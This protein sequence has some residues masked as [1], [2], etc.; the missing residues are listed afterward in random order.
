MNMNIFYKRSILLFVLLI[1]FSVFSQEILTKRIEKNYEMT[2]AGELHLNNKY[3]NVSITG[4]KKNSIEI[5]VEVKVTSKKAEDAKSLLNRIKPDFR[6]ATNYVNVTS[7]VAE[8]NENLFS[9]YFNKVN[10]FEFDKTNIEINYTVYLPEN[11]EI[12][13]TNKFGDVMVEDWTGKLKAEIEHGDLWINSSIVIADVEMKFGKLRAKTMTYGTIHMKNGSIKIEGSQDL[14]LRTSGTD[15]QI[16]KVNNLKLYSSKD[17]VVIDYLGNINGTVDFSDM[18]VN[19][20]DN[21]VYLEMKVTNLRILKMN[22]SDATVNINQE[23]SDISI[24]IS[25]LSFKFDAVL[26]EGLLRLPKTFTDVKSE[27]VDKGNRIRN[28]YASYGND[29]QGAFSFT[30][31]KG[32]ITLK[33]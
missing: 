8:K 19:E 11:A 20:M 32:V 6:T 25:G 16:D 3:G 5:V 12:E 26:E 30:G 22:R 33:E 31:K 21:D 15:I 10:P 4:W 29:L 18:Q 9:R 24:Y 1:S 7:E 14:M 13:I 2:N 17:E 27:L 23:S 28:I